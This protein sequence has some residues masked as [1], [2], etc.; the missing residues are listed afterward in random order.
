[1]AGSTA[2]GTAGGLEDSQTA[3]A[4]GS[5]SK[6]QHRPGAGEAATSGSRSPAAPDGRTRGQL[7]GLSQTVLLLPL[8]LQQRGALHPRL[9]SSS[10]RL[11]TASCR[12]VDRRIHRTLALLQEISVLDPTLGRSDWKEA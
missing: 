11:N 4:P 9:S 2:G 5:T 3:E 6:P 1:M 10:C 8:P 12:C 7:L